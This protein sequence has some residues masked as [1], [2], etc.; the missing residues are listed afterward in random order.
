MP[1]IGRLRISPADIGRRVSIRHLG[2]TDLTDVL[3]HLVSWVGDW[4]TGILSIRKKD[5]SSQEIVSG[6]IVAAIVIAPEI[7]SLDLQRYCENTWAPKEREQLGDWVLRFSG[8]ESARANSCRLDGLPE[9]SIEEGL[10]KIT[11]WYK[12]RNAVAIVQSPKPG[13]FDNF[14]IKNNWQEIV[15]ALYMVSETNTFQ[16]PTVIIE[17]DLS[18][19]WFDTALNSDSRAPKLS[20]E[21]LQSGDQV[22]FASIGDENK[23]IIA[24]GRVSI[25]SEI[26]MVTTVWVDEKYR[27]QGLA[28][29]IMQALSNEVYKLGQKIIVLQVLKTNDV[30]VG[31]YKSLGYEIH[32]ENS[33][34]RHTR[35]PA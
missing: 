22:R 30:A 29:T 2:G 11:S 21:L 26:A 14:L 10:E 8:N 35:K 20:R 12:Q 18:D 9:S 4:P 5:G 27:G 28:K 15:H 3:G 32:H 33:Y 16:T 34:Y 13:A 7:G 24:I 17:E 19:A 23:K 1:A 25:T 31:L 6:K